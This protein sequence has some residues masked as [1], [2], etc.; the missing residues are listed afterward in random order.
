MKTRRLGYLLGSGALL[1]IGFFSTMAMA[2]SRFGSRQSFWQGELG[3][4]STFVSD[5]GFDPFSSD[6]ALTQL[7]LGVARTLWAED[8]VS[9]APGVIWDYGWRAAT[10]RGQDTS[11]SSHRLALALEGRYHLFPFLYGLVRVTPGAVHQSVEVDDSLSPAPFVAKSWAFAL[12]ASAGAAFLLGPQHEDSASPVRWWLAAE[13][14]Y[15]YAGSTSLMM[16]PDLAEGDPR[17][18]GDLDLG[19]L[20]MRGAFF[21]IYGSVTY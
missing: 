18:T 4:R 20:A 14:G 5:P 12:D 6:N 3:V 7:S 10:A 17:R 2:E 16:H 1:G 21:R 19:T 9:F 15:S 11:I 13:G 8:R